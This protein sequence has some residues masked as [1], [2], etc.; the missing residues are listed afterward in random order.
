MPAKAAHQ[1]PLIR[2]AREGD[3]MALALAPGVSA[4]QL[5]HRWR[6]HEDGRRRMLVAEMDGQAAET[7][8][9]GD[10]RHERSGS[11]RVFALDV[12]PAFRGTGVCGRADWGGR[13]G[14]A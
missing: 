13:G 5:S 6:E 2:V 4:G 12:G 7:I 9:T 11:L 10:P 14:G 8:S 3:T 1:A